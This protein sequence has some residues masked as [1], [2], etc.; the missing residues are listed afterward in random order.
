MSTYLSLYAPPPAIA[1]ARAARGYTSLVLEAHFAAMERRAR[2]SR[3]DEFAEPAARASRIVRVK[4]WV[5]NRPVPLLP[6]THSEPALIATPTPGSIHEIQTVVA[7]YYGVTRQEILSH[8]RDSVMVKPRFVAYYLAK[9]LTNH[10][11][12]YIGRIF[13]N[14]DH[15]SVLS[16][17]KK[18]AR[19]IADGDKAL[20][21]DIV[22][23]R[24]ALTGG[25]S[26]P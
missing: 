10:S 9:E 4:E 24:S 7:R 16:G 1:H 12:P 8:K 3:V 5:P 21:E 6:L 23:L 15:T 19:L 2:M 13:D 26:S 25:R 18:I 17:C 22:L 14:R 20:A 11:L